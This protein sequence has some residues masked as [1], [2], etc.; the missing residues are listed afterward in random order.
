MGPLSQETAEEDILHGIMLLA[1]A[2]E[3]LDESLNE[4]RDRLASRIED[5]KVLLGLHLC[6]IE[7]DLTREVLLK[8][9]LLH[10]GPTDAPW[11]LAPLLARLA[12]G[13]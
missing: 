12:T 13:V 11:M 3:D 4:E 10:L 6:R 8:T 9:F 7:D 5:A 1:T 2:K